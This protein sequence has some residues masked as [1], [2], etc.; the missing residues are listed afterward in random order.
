MGFPQTPHPHVDSN[1]GEQ[2][3]DVILIRMTYVR[4]VTNGAIFV[5]YEKLIATT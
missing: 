2:V 3:N 1:K 5:T 4:Q